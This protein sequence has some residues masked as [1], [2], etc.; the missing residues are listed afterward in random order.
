MKRNRSELKAALLEQAETNIEE[1]LDWLEQSPAPTLTQIE[2][3][4]L[5]FRKEVGRA[6]AEMAIH[7]QDTVTVAPGPPC[8]KCG[9]EMRSKAQK[10]K[11]VTSRVGDLGLKRSHYYCPQCRR[12]FF[13]P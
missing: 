8:P 12:G 4:V 6:A 5:Q 3:A 10:T 7:A 2:D 11:Q 13:P 9:N 1:F